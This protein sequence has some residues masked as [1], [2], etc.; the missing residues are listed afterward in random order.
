MSDA[1]DDPSAKAK[2]FRQGFVAGA[3]AILKAI[4]DDL[5][6][7]QMR[8]L[9]KWVEGPLDKWRNAD[10]GASEPPIPMIDGA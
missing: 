9:Q 4:G 10:A 8:V 2:D 3:Q 5:P 6:E 1:T 7:Q